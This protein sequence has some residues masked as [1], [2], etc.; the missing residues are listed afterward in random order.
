MHALVVDKTA[1]AALRMAETAAPVP[2][3]TQVLIE[4]TH[5]SLNWGEVNHA[6]QGAEP[7]EVLGWD[8]AGV[9]RQAASAGGG[10]A[11][12]ARVVTFGATG[13]W[14]QRRAVEIA[15]VAVV[16][17]GVELATAAALPV[18]GV[19][20]LR[21][22]RAAGLA[23]GKRVLITGASGGVGRFA[24]QIAA[25]GGAHVIAAVGSPQRGA[26]LTDLGA[27][28]V[29]VG[30]DDISE[31]VDIVLESVGGPMLVRAFELLAVGGSLQSIGWTSR[32]PAVFPM[33]ATVGPAKSLTSFMM[34]DGLSEDLSTLLDLIVEGRL[35]VDI[36]WFGPWTRVAEAAAA[37]VGRQVSGKAVLE[38][39]SGVTL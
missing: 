7:G 3:P 4:V 12:G 2:G 30:L 20:A 36:G 15:D 35:T 38:V 19:T 25:L 14:A 21:A 32:E 39:A 34:G 33:Y 6:Q 17:D 26:G 29:V 18:A 5:A 16:P 27:S 28:E 23:P 22:L 13:G 8:A 1:E 10:P 11:V 37:L 24:V 31:P 9:V